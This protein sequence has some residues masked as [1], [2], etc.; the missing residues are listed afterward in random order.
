MLKKLAYELMLRTQAPAETHA[1]RQLTSTSSTN[2]S[3]TIERF[4]SLTDMKSVQEF[5]LERLGVAA[6]LF[7]NVIVFIDGVSVKGSD[8][9]EKNEDPNSEASCA[10]HVLVQWLAAR[11]PQH[12]YLML[13]VATQGLNFVP[14]ML[15]VIWIR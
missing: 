11:L 3:A 12:V 6:R 15:S 8:T 5:V 2:T 7:A 10:I 9:D 4:T 13:T 14:V 1:V